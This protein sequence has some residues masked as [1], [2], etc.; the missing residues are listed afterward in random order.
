MW[1]VVNRSYYLACRLWPHPVQHSRNLEQM[2]SHRKTVDVMVEVE[3]VKFNMYEQQ[4]KSLK[5]CSTAAAEQNSGQSDGAHSL[6]FYEMLYRSELRMYWA[7]AN[8]DGMIAPKHEQQPI[9]RNLIWNI[10]DRFNK[11]ITNRTWRRNDIGNNKLLF[12]FLP[13]T[14]KHINNS[15]F[16]ATMRGHQ[17]P[18]RPPG[19]EAN[20]CRGQTS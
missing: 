8:N 6:F 13:H 16:M 7:N 17:A 2:R 10:F 3:L 20:F 9:Q 1:T 12:V 15:W 18:R 4:C 11:T 5:K 14:F 19:C